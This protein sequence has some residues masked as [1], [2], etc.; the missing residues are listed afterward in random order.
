MFTSIHLEADCEQGEVLC[1]QV[2]ARHCSE[3]K[4]EEQEKELKRSLS[5]QEK[6]L[7]LLDG[8][9]RLGLANG[10]RPRR[11]RFSST[12]LMLELVCPTK[13]GSAASRFAVGFWPLRKQAADVR[14]DWAA[15]IKPLDVCLFICLCVCLCVCLFVCVC[16]YMNSAHEMYH[17]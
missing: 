9:L 5:G 14:Q 12:S 2:Q 7:R 8:T 17:W 1:L 13:R 3:L 16:S 11:L 6:D 15:D 10:F 4:F